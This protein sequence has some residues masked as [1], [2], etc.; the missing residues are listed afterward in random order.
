MPI[1]SGTFKMSLMLILTFFSEFWR[2]DSG[3]PV[4]ILSFSLPIPSTHCIP[5]SK[6]YLSMAQRKGL[7]RLQKWLKH[8]NSSFTNWKPWSKSFTRLQVTIASWDVNAHFFNGKIYFKYN[9]F[10]IFYWL[11]Q[12]NYTDYGQFCSLLTM[13]TFPRQLIS[14]L[15]L[16]EMI[17]VKIME[18]IHCKPTISRQNWPSQL[19]LDSWRSFSN[20]PLFCPPVYCHKKPTNP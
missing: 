9:V 20:F 15:K 19:H 17:H 2:A 7:K 5:N 6:T 11:I 3:K 18:L 12:F 4:F 1:F 13:N 10:K 16:R 8:V 14:P